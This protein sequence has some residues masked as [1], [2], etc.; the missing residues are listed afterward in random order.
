[1]HA[2]CLGMNGAAQVVV[3][4]LRW[5]SQIAPGHASHTMADTSCGMFVCKGVAS[6]LAVPF[7]V[8]KDTIALAEAHS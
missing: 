4:S 3:C 7:N 8:V 1:M 6:S 2:R 5:K